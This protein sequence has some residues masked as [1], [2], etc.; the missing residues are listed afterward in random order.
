MHSWS[1]AQLRGF[2]EYKAEEIG[3]TVVGIDPRY[4][5]QACSKCGFVHRSNR[6]SQSVFK[7]RSCGYEL[8]ADLNASVNIAQKYHVEDGIAVLDAPLSIGVSSP[9]SFKTESDKPSPLGDGS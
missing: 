6:R 7:C 5:S 8:N 4:T 1:F 2:L 9:R 3:S